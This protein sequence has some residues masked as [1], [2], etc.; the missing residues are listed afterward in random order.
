MLKKPSVALLKGCSLLPNIFK[1]MQKKKKKLDH[2]FYASVCF[3][4]LT[5]STAS[6][7]EFLSGW[8]FKASFL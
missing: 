6:G 8:Y 3:I 2:E 4:Q 7:E 1:L 5:F